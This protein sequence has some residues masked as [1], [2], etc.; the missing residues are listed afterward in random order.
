MRSDGSNM[1]RLGA[2][3]NPEPRTAAHL[4]D[5]VFHALDV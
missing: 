3:Y 4:V 1:D 5:A 2:Y